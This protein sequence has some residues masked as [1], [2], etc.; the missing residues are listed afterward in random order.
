MF[1]DNSTI[2]NLIQ[3]QLHIYC[4]LFEVQQKSTEREREREREREHE[5]PYM[6]GYSFRTLNKRMG[7]GF[8]LREYMNKGVLST[9][10]G[11][12]ASCIIKL[13]PPHKVAG[14]VWTRYN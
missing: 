9:S 14:F 10:S 6:N 7:M 13:P 8:L 3:P 11:T 4:T 1:L 12:T 5:G 2:I